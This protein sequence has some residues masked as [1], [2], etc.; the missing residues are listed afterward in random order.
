MEANFETLKTST[1]NLNA[2]DQFACRLAAAVEFERQERVRQ[3]FEE[4]DELERARR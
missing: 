1:A 2:F 4:E 3:S